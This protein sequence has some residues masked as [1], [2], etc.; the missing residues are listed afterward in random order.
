[1]A[2][3]DGIRTL[4]L[5]QSSITTLCPAQS[6]INCIFVDTVKQGVNP[7]YIR[8]RRAKHDPMSCLDG[9]YGMASSDIEIECVSFTEPGSAAIAKAVTDFFKDYSGAAG[10]SDTID[11][12]IWDDTADSNIQDQGGDDVYRYSTKLKFVVQHH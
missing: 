5:A 9:T 1:M 12:V 2:L 11:A 10:A 6:S 7:P 3:K 8:I 4:L